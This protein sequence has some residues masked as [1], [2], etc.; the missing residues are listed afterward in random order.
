MNS[1]VAALDL[2][3]NTFL[4]LIART[5]ADGRIE[6]LDDQCRTPRIGAGL[7]T[8]GALS[9][10]G[11]QRGL[12]VLAEF[13]ERLRSA[14]LDAARIRVV[15]T[16]ALRRARNAAEFIA[17]ARE[18]TGLAIEVLSEE[19]EARVG[20]AAATAERDAASVRVVDV[21][22]GSTQITADGGRSR[23][24]APVGA[25][26][27]T[28]RWHG[29]LDA[30]AWS[31]ASWSAM[32][33]DVRRACSVFPARER[34]SEVDDV[35]VLGGTGANLACLELGLRAFEPAAVEGTVI[36]VPQVA[37]WAERLRMLDVPARLQLPIERERAQIL[38]AGLACLTAALA[39]LGAQRVTISG[40]GVRY[41]VARELLAASALLPGAVP[42]RAPRVG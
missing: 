40:R 12:D 41:G 31:D 38:P 32:Q 17:A 37:H 23:V 2:G 8:T 28:E 18:R 6:V 7:A 20:F 22:G 10:E 25:V 21:G 15:G 9:A 39:R 34:A 19:E 5:G 3:T 42:T 27:L 36:A 14:D 30:A 4:L 35:I 33:N 13:R 16:A 24:S 26:V 29:G 1:A 11:M